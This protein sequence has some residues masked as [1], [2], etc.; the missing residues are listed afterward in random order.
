MWVRGGGLLDDAAG[1][2]GPDGV[3]FILEI[4]ITS[5]AGHQFIVGSLFHNFSTCITDYI[6]CIA[7]YYTIRKKRI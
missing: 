5:I 3:I 2:Y 7:T 6:P 4:L 1:V